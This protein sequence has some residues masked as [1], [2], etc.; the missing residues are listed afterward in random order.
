MRIL[1]SRN[2][3][4]DAERACSL[5]DS[6]VRDSLSRYE[7][8]IDRTLYKT[9]HELKRLQADRRGHAVIAPIVVDITGDGDQ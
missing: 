3:R 2:G 7:A 6:G 9:I 8:Q 5:P 4:E 1:A